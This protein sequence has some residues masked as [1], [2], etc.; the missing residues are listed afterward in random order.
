MVVVV[1]ID[2]DGAVAIRKHAFTARAVDVSMRA[3][4]TDAT[5]RLVLTPVPI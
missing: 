5:G 4:T 3:G 1:I 2:E